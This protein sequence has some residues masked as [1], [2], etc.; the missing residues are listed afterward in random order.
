MLSDFEKK[1]INI[2]NKIIYLIIFLS[3][4]L[5][6][7]ILYK[8]FYV[9][10]NI[11]SNNANK[12]YT[13]YYYPYIVF[14]LIFILFWTLIIFFT[15]K[16]KPI[17]L[18]IFTSIIFA[19]Y[20]VEIFFFSN[21][22]LHFKK[23][24]NF[25]NFDKRSKIEVMQ[26]LN[27]PNAVTAISPKRIF[28]DDDDVKK[29][30]PLSG[31]SNSKTVMCNERG[32][33]IIYQSDRFGFNNPDYTWENNKNDFILLG[34]SFAYG[35]CVYQS[36]NISSKLREKNFNNLNL[37]YSGNGPLS[38]LGTLKEFHKI[39]NPQYI[40]WLYYEG[41]DLIDLERELNYKSFNF[42][43]YL[44]KDYSQN[45]SKKQAIVDK[46]LKELYQ[47]RLKQKLIEISKKHEN[48]IKQNGFLNKIHN[49]DYKKALKLYNLRT[50]LGLV[51]VDHDQNTYD[52][53]ISIL[54]EAKIF[55]ENNNSELI[56]IYL[57]RYYKTMKYVNIYNKDKIINLVNE[58]GINIIDIDKLVFK[59]HIDPLSLFP[60]KRKNHYSNEGYSL[61][62]DE[63]AKYFLDK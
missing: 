11:D 50:L 20:F 61:V 30:V 17:I 43:N 56:F 23:P 55:S 14:F 46:V 24:Y 22:W 21:I 26:D 9:Y 39:T 34:D 2:S 31:I 37:A 19:L 51:Y 10:S 15:S 28:I 18:I 44:Q 13:D 32:E 8:Y 35:A 57:P 12:T 25:E 48:I 45:L 60:F 6:F 49:F 41:N 27:D 1:L 33:W 38:M 47:K 52:S 36:E 59:K 58:L 29:I 4:I 3:F 16:F 53:F 40:L 42:K 54:N 5:L 62:A 7:Y 63:I